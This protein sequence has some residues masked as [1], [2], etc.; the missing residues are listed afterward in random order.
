MFSFVSELKSE[1]FLGTKC[2]G[3]S[4]PRAEHNGFFG[5]IESV[6]PLVEWVTILTAFDILVEH[7]FGASPVM[8]SVSEHAAPP[9]SHSL[10]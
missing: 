2:F 5:G 4:Y 7:F 1:Y 9:Y 6:N 3:S 10:D 8:F